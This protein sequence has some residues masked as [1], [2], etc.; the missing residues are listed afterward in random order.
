MAKGIGRNG[1]LF[2]TLCEPA[3]LMA[4][5]RSA[6]RG[7]KRKPDAAAFLLNMEPE[8]FRLAAELAA[9]T[10]IPGAYRSYVIREPKPRLISAAPFADRVVHHAL[11]SLLEPHFERR[12][13]THSYACRVGKGTHRALE[14]A[15]EL[16]GRRRFVLKGDIAKFFPSID[17]AIL[18]AQVRR[19]IADERL[20]AVLERVVDGSNPQEL[21]EEWFPGDDLFT[22]AGRRRGIPIGNLT[23]QFLANVY[24]DAFDH[25]VMDRE[26]FGDYVR[27]C[28]DFLVFADDR[29]ALWA[30]RGRLEAFLGGLRLRLHARK[31]G[32]HATRSPVPFLGF[33]VR[34]GR[35]RLQRPAVVRAT[36]RLRATAE[37]HDEGTVDAETLR[38]R[39]AAW[40]GHAAHASDP[41]IAAR[42][43]ARA[44]VPA[45]E[46][47]GRVRAALIRSTTNRVIRGGSWN[48]DT[49]NVRSSNRNNDTPGNTNNNIGFRV[50]S[51]P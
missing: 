7:K 24:M 25:Q 46:L 29:D 45:A 15:T 27:Y 30:L 10:W 2:R 17:H 6:A 34:D 49:N 48:N 26:G 33:V 22:P 21:V 19:V 23:S 43:V 35:R 13:V 9:G 12:F 5:A 18:K 47:R 44:G 28:D 51:T 40:Q 8:C 31:G 20:L 41:A 4:C 3:H 32:V 1:E 37:G 16:S 42:V 38:A 36:R 39:V 11:V 50:A 14:R